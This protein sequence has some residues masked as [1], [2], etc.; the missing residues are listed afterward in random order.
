MSITMKPKPW[1]APC[2]VIAALGGP[3]SVGNTLI[4]KPNPEIPI[5]TGAMRAGHCW[6]TER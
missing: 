2:Q 5:S 1:I 4:R 6:R 3:L